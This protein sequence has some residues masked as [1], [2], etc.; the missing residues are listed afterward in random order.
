MMRRKQTTY[1]NVGSGSSKQSVGG[2][3]GLWEAQACW[4]VEAGGGGEG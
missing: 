1:A 2:Q 4:A 3:P